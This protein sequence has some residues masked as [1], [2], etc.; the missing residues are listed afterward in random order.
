[1]HSHV[2]LNQEEHLDLKVAEG[3]SVA[4]GDGT[5]STMVFPI[6]FRNVQAHYPIFFQKHPDTGQFYSVAL[7][8]FET[9][10]NLFIDDD[11]WRANYVPLMMRKQPFYIGLK[12]DASANDGRAM[13][14]TLDPSHP[15]ANVESGQAVFNQ[16]GSPTEFLQQKMEVLEQVHQGHEHAQGFCAALAEHDLLEP[17][18]LEVTL[19]DGSTNQLLGFYS[20]NEEKVQALTGQ[21]LED[22]ASKGYLISLF[23]V[24]ASHSCIADLI[25][26]KNLKTP[27]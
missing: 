19:H 24:M 7:F 10:E 5:N 1:M 27:S 17:L 18:T 11:E 13:I 20:L 6:E 14:V 2:L 9:A 8:G 21:V 23:M 25:A 16:D 4:M 26:K 15:K 22:F 3:Y 12:D